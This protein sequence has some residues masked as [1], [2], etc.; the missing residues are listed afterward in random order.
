[1]SKRPPR[2]PGY[3]WLIPYLTVKDCDAAL[4]FYQK[5][6]GFEK[7]FA[8]PGPDGKSVHVEMMWHDAMIMFGSVPESKKAEWPCRTPIE[9]GVRSP[10][11]PYVYCDDVDALYARAVAAGAGGVKPPETMFY[12][13][14]VCTLADTDGYWW[15]FAT[16]VADFDPSK[17]PK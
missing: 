13:D 6:F 8:M 16:N 14:R 15:N 1:M 11:V 10:I 7:R 4:A 9:Q 12:G 3:P 17:A 2:Q 5:A